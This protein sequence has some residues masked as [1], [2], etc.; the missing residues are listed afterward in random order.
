MTEALEPPTDELCAV[1]HGT[2]SEDHGV[3]VGVAVCGLCID[4]LSD[5]RRKRLDQRRLAFFKAR[6]GPDSVP[7]GGDPTMP[8]R[9]PSPSDCCIWCGRTYAAHEPSR[10]GRAIEPKAPCHNRREHFVTKLSE[11]G[12]L[13]RRR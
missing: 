6:S 10:D 3:S 7:G 13:T 8:A 2:L 9:L 1:C 12:N 5:T 11:L 4:A